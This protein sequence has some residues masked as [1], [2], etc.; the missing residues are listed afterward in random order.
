MARRQPFLPRPAPV[1]FVVREKRRPDLLAIASTSV[2]QGT[3]WQS[4]IASLQPAIRQPCGGDPA[5]E[6]RGW[7][8]FPEYLDQGCTITHQSDPIGSEDTHRNDRATNPTKLSEIVDDRLDG[9]EGRLRLCKS[10]RSAIWP[11]IQGRM[12]RGGQS[13]HCSGHLGRERI[14]QSSNPTAS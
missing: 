11:V 1:S 8:I 12:R 6:F 14:T 3:T 7:A 13:N 10:R 2:L 9:R 4:S 5:S